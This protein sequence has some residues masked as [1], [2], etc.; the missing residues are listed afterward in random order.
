MWSHCSSPDV[1]RRWQNK[2]SLDRNPERYT[3]HLVSVEH[4][5]DANSQH[6]NP[7]FQNYKKQFAYNA[8][9]RH[10]CHAISNLARDLAILPEWLSRLFARCLHQ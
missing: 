8:F 3:D 4:R 5:A 9:V 2:R 7:S 1:H 6:I 10:H